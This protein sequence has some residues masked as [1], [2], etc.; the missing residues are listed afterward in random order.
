MG[1]TGSALEIAR[2]EGTCFITISDLA[3]MG[4]AGGSFQI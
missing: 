4:A 1:A 3:A 2:K